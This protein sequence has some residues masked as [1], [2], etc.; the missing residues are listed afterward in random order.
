MPGERVRLTY[1]VHPFLSDEVLTVLQ[2][3]NT[4]TSKA[5][6]WRIKCRGRE[7]FDKSGH[8]EGWLDATDVELVH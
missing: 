4:G 3:T 5:P 1:R 2:S 8:V 6:L 7:L